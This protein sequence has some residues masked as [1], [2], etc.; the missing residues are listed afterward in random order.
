MHFTFSDGGEMAEEYDVRTDEL[1]GTCIAG[2]MKLISYY[3]TLLWQRGSCILNMM[4]M[5]FFLSTSCSQVL[6]L[7]VFYN[8]FSFFVMIMSNFILNHFGLLGIFSIIWRS[9]DGKMMKPISLYMHGWGVNELFVL[10]HGSLNLN[11][12]NCLHVN[13]CVPV[14][15][16]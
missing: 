7:I 2:N 15:P 14:L 9:K 13:V 5:I 4:I 16:F 6:A 11:I 3:Y 8:N 1:L 10:S 12:L